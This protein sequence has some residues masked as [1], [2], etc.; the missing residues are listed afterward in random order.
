M[1]RVHEAAQEPVPV[2]LLQRLPWLH[3]VDWLLLLHIKVLGTGSCYRAPTCSLL[4]LD[5]VSWCSLEL[6]DGMPATG[7]IA[8][9]EGAWAV[10]N[11]AAFKAGKK[12]D[13][14]RAVFRRGEIGSGPV[15]MYFTPAAAAVAKVFGA[16]EC[17]KPSPPGIVLFLG[18]ARAWGIHFPVENDETVPGKVW[19]FSSGRTSSPG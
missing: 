5:A 3:W 18:D 10:L 2:A 13:Y 16:V 19:Q 15:T 4:K 12:A 11:E 17:G 9:I 14:S 7:P 6:G 1:D 8:Q